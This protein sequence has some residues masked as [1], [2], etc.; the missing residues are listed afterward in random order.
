MP[1]ITEFHCTSS[2]KKYVFPLLKFREL[3]CTSQVHRDFAFEVILKDFSSLSHE[4]DNGYKQVISRSVCH[5]SPLWRQLSY[6]RGFYENNILCFNTFFTTCI[7]FHLFGNLYNIE[8]CIS[9]YKL[10]RCPPCNLN[11]CTTYPH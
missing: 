5:E 11:T 1:T 8:N 10:K 4:E 7:F 2:S 3:L 9:G 6:V